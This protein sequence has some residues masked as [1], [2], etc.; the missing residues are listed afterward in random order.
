MYTDHFG[1]REPPFSLTPDPRYVFMSVRHREALAHLVYGIGQEGGFVQLTGDV[2]TGKTTMSR[3]LLG[4]LSPEVDVALIINPRLTSEELLAAVCDEL[5][6]PYPAGPITVKALVDA[7]HRYLLDAHGRGR[8][9]V[10]I[11]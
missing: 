11:I 1:L 2:G 7:L 10:L 6:V 4:Q 9:T 5:R 3:C 8:R